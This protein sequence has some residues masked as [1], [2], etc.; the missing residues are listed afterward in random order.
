M[1]KRIGKVSQ[2]LNIGI[3]GSVGVSVPGV[4]DPTIAGGIAAAQAAA[5]A[6]Q[7]QQQ[8]SQA[9][10]QLGAPNLLGGAPSPA[11]EGIY[12]PRARVDPNVM[13]RHFGRPAPSPQVPIDPFG[14]VPPGG[15]AG[16]PAPAPTWPIVATNPLAGQPIPGV[17]VFGV[18]G[19]PIAG[20]PA[21]TPPLTVGQGQGILGA[22]AAG[23]PG[24]SAYVN[25]VTRSANSGHPLGILAAE[26][27]SLA[28]RLQI[29]AKFVARYIGPNEAA[30]ILSGLHS[31]S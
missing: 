19:I 23:D 24:A 7:A 14:G 25:G 21:V 15:Y 26:V 20:P 13:T 30:L 27:L 16:A 6:A 4:P 11:P 28:Q 22:A 2:G 8:A 5:Q 1:G 9:A 17:P 10:A 12:T 31:A 29:Q 3:G 18:V